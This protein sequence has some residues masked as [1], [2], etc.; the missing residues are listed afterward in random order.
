MR[1]ICLKP[2]EK[3]SAARRFGARQMSAGTV[4]RGFRAW[5]RGCRLDARGMRRGRRSRPALHSGALLLTC[6]S[7][8]ARRAFRM[9]VNASFVAA[10][11]GTLARL[12]SG[13]KSGRRK[14]HIVAL[15]PRPARL[16]PGLSPRTTRAR[17]PRFRSAAA[18]PSRPG[19]SSVMSSIAYL[20]SSRPIPESSDSGII[21]PTNF[22]SSFGS[23]ILKRLRPAISFSRRRAVEKTVPNR[24]RTISV[25]RFPDPRATLTCRAPCS[26]R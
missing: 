5:R 17:R 15:R 10:I 11:R 22:F 12:G 2:A 20:T 23:P 3:L 4:R 6:Y 9:H 19:A 14:P 18:R 21:G 8:I 25:F 7:R 13:S 26:C 16:P 24:F 1:E